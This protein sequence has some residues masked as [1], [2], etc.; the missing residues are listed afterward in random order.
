MHENEQLL[1]TIN[2]GLVVLDREL[3][4]ISWNRW[5][6]QHSGIS[7]QEIIGTFLSGSFPKFAEPKYVRF[8]KAV[9][10]FG[11]YAY[12]SQRLHNYLFTMKNP[13]S[14]IDAIPYMQQSCA[15]GPLRDESG[16][17]N[18][19]FISVQDV[20]DN[21]VY[22]MRLR[23]KLIELEAA[24]AKVKQL[25]GIIP[26]CMYCMKIR[27]DEQSWQQMER[28]ISEHSE[29]HFSHGICPE[30]FTKKPWM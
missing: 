6:E 9:F 14:S 18:R 17:I 24:L 23:Q 28:Y 13:N 30:C 16:L 2:T 10:A 5:M 22:E 27:D 26:I 25:E 21:V 11:N 12:F 8:L 1:Y 19:I 7:R 29:A 15:A 3:V 4:V 20:T